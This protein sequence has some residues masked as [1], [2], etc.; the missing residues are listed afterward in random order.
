VIAVGFYSG[1]VIVTDSLIFNFDAG[2]DKCTDADDDVTSMRDIGSVAHSSRTDRGLTG[3][4][5]TGNF[6][7]PT[8][9]GAVKSINIG[10][11]GRNSSVDA[12]NYQNRI[13]LDDDILLADESAWTF[14][15]WAKPNANAEHTFLSLAGRGATSP[16]FIWQHG[17]TTFYPR[18][19]DNNGNYYRD[20]ANTNCPDPDDWHQVVFTADTSRNISFYKD[21]ELLGGSVQAADT[22]TQFNR[23]MAGYSSG[24]TRYN[25]QGDFLCIRV[26]SKTL[27]A[28]EVLQNFNATRRRVGI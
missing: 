7:F 13:G 25:F 17:S 14:E 4:G 1:P 9:A 18:Y 23:F 28:A 6:S 20:S 3:A 19:R 26:Y 21:G 15:F 10:V 27:S 24:T 12:T 2:N 16:W 22:Q 11:T 8:N 5:E